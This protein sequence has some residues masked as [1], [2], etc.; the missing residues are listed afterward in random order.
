MSLEQ[1]GELHG[2]AE[3]TLWTSGPRPQ[4]L[5][6]LPGPLQEDLTL[7]GDFVLGDT[8]WFFLETSLLLFVYHR[9][10]RIGETRA[11]LER[12]GLA[13]RDQT[14]WIRKTG[15]VFEEPELD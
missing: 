4:S 9:L 10:T 6:L 1:R 5:W 15:P 13:E 3:W 7:E 2:S 11:G 8:Q 14:S 12:L